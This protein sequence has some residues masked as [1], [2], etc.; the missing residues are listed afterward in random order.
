MG[1]DGAGGLGYARG[2]DEGKHERITADVRDFQLGRTYFLDEEEERS[3]SPYREQEL[4]HERAGD[5]PPSF[6]DDSVRALREFEE[7][8]LDFEHDEYGYE[9]S[10]YF[11]CEGSSSRS[12]IAHGRES[13]VAVYPRVV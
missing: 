2:N 1:D 12:D 3:P 6:N 8:G 11:R 7:S 10:R 4:P 5:S 13:E 9:E